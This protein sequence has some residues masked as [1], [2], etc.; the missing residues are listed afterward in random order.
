MSILLKVDPLMKVSG[1]YTHAYK[2]QFTI[3]GILNLKNLPYVADFI[4][5]YI[6]GTY[7]SIR[8]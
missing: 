7:K 5:F 6:L 4:G 2:S 1:V 3:T 8:L